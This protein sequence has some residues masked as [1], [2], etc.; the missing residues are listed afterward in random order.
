MRYSLALAMSR[1]AGKP[2]TQD[3]ARQILDEACPVEGAHIPL[4][5]FEPRHWRG[6]TIR[7]ER[8]A[9]Q[10]A[11]LLALEAAFREEVGFT[12]NLH[13]GAHAARLREDEAAGVLLLL[14]ARTAAG[15]IAGAMRIRVWVHVA[16]QS[17]RACDEMLY[18]LPAHRGWLGVHLARYAEACAFQLGARE[19]TLTCQDATDSGRLARFAGYR[20]VATIYKLVAQDAC[21]ITRMPTRHHRHGVAHEP[22]L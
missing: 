20:K 12:G 11:A 8:I 19:I 21:D 9:G 6:Y 3:L 16:S 5:Q 17:I 22:V 13:A 15:E 14:V 18:V 7:P 4:D 10:E 1:H 2:L